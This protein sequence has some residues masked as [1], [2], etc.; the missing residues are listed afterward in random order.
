V[1]DVRTK[2]SQHQQ[3]S[4]RKLRKAKGYAWEVRFSEWLNGKRYQRS[5]TFQ[6]AEYPKEADF[7]KA[8]EKRLPAMVTGISDAQCS[9]PQIGLRATFLVGE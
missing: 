7:R 1:R 9:P 2:R 3:G 4:I 5:M 8:I 6:G